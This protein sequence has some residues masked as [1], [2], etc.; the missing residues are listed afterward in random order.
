MADKTFQ[1]YI[2]SKL[3][4]LHNAK[5][6]KIAPDYVTLNELSSAVVTELRRELNNLFSQG[7]IKVGDTLNGKYIVSHRWE[8]SS[9]QQHTTAHTTSEH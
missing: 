9:R 6:G 1:D 4:E 8:N 2:M 7:K 3:D 5:V